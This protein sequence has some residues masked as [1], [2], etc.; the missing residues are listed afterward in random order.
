M[1]RAKVTQIRQNY[2]SQ[3]KKFYNLNL[4]TMLWVGN[5]FL[6][7]ADNLSK[8]V[9]GLQEEFTNNFSSQLHL[10]SSGPQ[11]KKEKPII[12]DEA[13]TFRPHF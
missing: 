6:A 3:N 9:A 8:D 4:K 12:G 10:E 1:G 7:K 13:M 5:P 11:L 2:F